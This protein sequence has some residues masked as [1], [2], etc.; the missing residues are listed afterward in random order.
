MAFRTLYEEL[1]RSRPGQCDREYLRILH[2]AATTSE[3][4]VEV[5]LALLEESRQAVNW[6]AVRELVQPHTRAVSEAVRGLVPAQPQ[7]RLASYDRLLSV[8][9]VALEPR[10]PQASTT[11]KDMV[12]GERENENEAEVRRANG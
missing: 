6:D 7:P 12:A 9:V 11:L 4:E 1:V 5:A 3:S 10:Q 2:L 8:S